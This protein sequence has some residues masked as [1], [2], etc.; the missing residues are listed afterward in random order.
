MSFVETPPLVSIIVG[1]RS[2]ENTIG[3]CIESL[4]NQDYISVEII[5]IDDGSDDQTSE[6]VK[7]YPVRLIRTEKRGISHA[8]NLGYLEAKAEFVAY[9]DADCVVVPNWLSTLMPHFKDPKV[10]LIGGMTVF[11]TDGSI[12]SLYRQVEFQKRNQNIL[13]G[14]VFWAG[15]PG[16]V[17]RKKVLDEVGGFNPQWTYGEDAEISFMISEKGYKILKEPKA[18]SYHAPESGFKKLIRK[19]YRDGSAYM[20]ATLFHVRKSLKNR[21]NTTWYLPYDVVFQPMLYAIL[22]M[23]WPVLLLLQILYNSPIFVILTVVSFG[24]FLFLFIYS[25]LPAKDVSR[26]TPLNR[27]KLKLFLGSSFLHILRGFAWGFGLLFGTLKAIKM[28]LSSS[29][30]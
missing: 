8:R 27:S 16:C 6:I 12:S 5:I 2:M 28:K 25:F 23:A 17:F 26:N 19:G 3:N 18:I 1:V 4:L 10:A 21:F 9:T 11:Q 14:E 30:Q 22:I 20:R 29:N 24:I 13:D 15:G 7:N